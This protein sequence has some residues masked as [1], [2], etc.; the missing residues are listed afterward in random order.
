MKPFRVHYCLLDR[1][2]R[3]CYAPPW[4]YFHT[5]WGALVL[6]VPPLM[7][8]RDIEWLFNQPEGV[9]VRYEDIPYR[10]QWHRPVQWHKYSRGSI[11]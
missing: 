6:A 9:A 3:E 8:G 4:L 2:C 11:G 10:W 7:R 5:P 1:E